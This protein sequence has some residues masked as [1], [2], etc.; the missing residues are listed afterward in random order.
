MSLITKLDSSV[1]DASL[2]KIDELLFNVNI[3]EAASKYRVSYQYMAAGVGGEIKIAL[4]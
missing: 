4:G 1:D 3:P 2:F